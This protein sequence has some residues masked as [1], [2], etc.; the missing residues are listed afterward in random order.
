MDTS[1]K[2]QENL[3]LNNTTLNQLLDY[4][5]FSNKVEP[6]FLK[7]MKLLFQRK[8]LNLRNDIAHGAFGYK[9]YYHISAT[10]VLYFMSTFVIK[11]EYLK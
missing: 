1:N 6:T 2:D 9:N 7:I 5:I 4:S 10:S 11:D 8:K 3:L